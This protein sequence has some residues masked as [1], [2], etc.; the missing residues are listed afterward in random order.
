MK[1]RLEF[2][3]SRAISFA[4][5][6]RLCKKFPT[7]KE[8]EEEGIKIY[9]IEVTDTDTDLSSLET[10]FNKVR[11]WK[12]VAYFVNDKLTAASDVFRIIWDR[13]YR[14]NRAL[15]KGDAKG[16]IDTL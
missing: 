3:E 10:I 9:S 16:F 1:I 12:Q 5:M 13:K 15:Y 2:A 11:S 14:R 8:F 4:W 6:L 7:F